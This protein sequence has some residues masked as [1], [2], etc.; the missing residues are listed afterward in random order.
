MGRSS[1][2]LGQSWKVV[3]TVACAGILFLGLHRWAYSTQMTKSLVVS[4]MRVA[5]V[6]ATISSPG[7]SSTTTTTLNVITDVHVG[8]SRCLTSAECVVVTVVDLAGSP[9][10]AR[11]TLGD[12]ENSCGALSMTTGI[13]VTDR[14]VALAVS[15]TVS[16]S[17]NVVAALQGF[18]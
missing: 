4:N 18:N 11:L 6:N 5:R 1:F 16:S 2:G 9:V 8:L 7:G 17:L 13:D 3:V 12:D 10:Y 14:N 15:A